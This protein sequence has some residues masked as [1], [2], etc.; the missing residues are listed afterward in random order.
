MRCRI[1]VNLGCAATC[2]LAGCAADHD[3]SAAKPLTAK[4]VVETCTLFTDAMSRRSLEITGPGR[5]VLTELTPQA[6]AAHQDVISSTR[7]TVT[8]GTY[9]I[10]GDGLGVTITLAG[11]QFR[12]TA[13]APPG[14]SEC[15]LLDGAPSQANLAGSWFADPDPPDDGG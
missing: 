7:V 4:E 2:A 3:K 6:V 10:A 14:V 15:L 13:F 1:G 5:V 12:Y 8:H 9:S 11:R